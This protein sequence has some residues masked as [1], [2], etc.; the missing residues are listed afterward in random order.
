MGLETL[1]APTVL[2]LD[3]TVHSAVLPRTVPSVTSRCTPKCSIMRANTPVNSGPESEMR[4]SGAASGRNHGKKAKACRASAA[5]KS[6]PRKIFFG[7]TVRY[8][9]INE[10]QGGS[11]LCKD[12]RK[13]NLSAAEAAGIHLEGRTRAL[14][15]ESNK[16]EGQGRF[17]HGDKKVA[18]QIP[19]HKRSAG[20]NEWEDA[21]IRTSC[22]VGSLSLPGT[23]P[24]CAHGEQKIK[25][26][27]IR[28]VRWT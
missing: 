2:P 1:H 9:W 8:G 16:K 15:E 19:S 4:T 21:I 11:E 28:A 10:C 6:S 23:R 14:P 24:A 5:V 20:C 26:L 13:L 18:W 17:T 27:Q 3:V 25:H 7:A 22:D 12:I